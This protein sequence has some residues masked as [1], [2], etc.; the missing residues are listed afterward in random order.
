MSLRILFVFVIFFTQAI[1]DRPTGLRLREYIMAIGANAEN[2]V[3]GTADP[4]ATGTINITSGSHVMVTLSASTASEDP[5]TTIGTLGWTGSGTPNFALLGTINWGS[6]RRTWWY[7]LTGISGD[8]TITW[9]HPGFQEV[10]I[11]ADE[12]TGLN[13]TT[14]ITGFATNSTSGGP[15]D[16]AVTATAAASP[17]AGDAT[18]SSIAL[19]SD[20]DISPEAGWTGLS[21]TSG[22]TL[23]VRRIET[24]WDS[25]ADTTSTWTWSGGNASGVA[26]W[27]LKTDGAAVTITPLAFNVQPYRGKK[28]AI[29][30]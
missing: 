15:S 11:T 26:I 8:G 22:G 29:S 21:A 19:E 13:A 24:A 1:P 25:D 30:Y 28:K 3:V 18:Y 7:N 27:I 6:R 5:G 4:F 20:V 2:A 10:G 23:G 16:V 12:I 9:D 17:S 14:P